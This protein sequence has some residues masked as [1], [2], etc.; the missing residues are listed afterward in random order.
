MKKPLSAVAKQTSRGGLHRSLGIPEDEKIGP[1]RIAAATHSSD[2][3]TRREA[4]LA[5]TYAAHRPGNKRAFH[6]HK[7]AFR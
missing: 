2:E 5:E 1:A 3:K 4:I 6:E 7:T